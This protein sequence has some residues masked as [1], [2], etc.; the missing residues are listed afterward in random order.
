VANLPPL[1]VFQSFNMAKAFRDFRVFR[2]LKKPRSSESFREQ[3][4]PHSKYPLN[5]RIEL[6]GTAR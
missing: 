6:M 4:A 2:G 1:F 5:P 3:A